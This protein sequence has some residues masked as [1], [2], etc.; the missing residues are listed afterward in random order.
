MKKKNK[1]CESRNTEAANRHSSIA[2]FKTCLVFAGVVFIF[3][4]IEWLLLKPAHL[5]P[6]QNLTAQTVAHL[7]N[8]SGINTTLRGTHIFF[9]GVHWEIVTECTALQA[10]YV[11]IAFISSYPSSI[12]AKLIG[13]FSGVPFLF[14]AN[15]IRLFVLA[16]AHHFSPQYAE[17][18]HDYIWQIAF[19]FLL[20]LMW[21]FWIDMVVKREEIS[22]IPA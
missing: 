14:A 8:L 22:A 11:F 21:I 18:V 7:I 12:K 15:V 17:I 2:L 6:Y 10:M 19:L 5:S 13:V 20:I 1:N 3:N 4:L 16:W 9:E